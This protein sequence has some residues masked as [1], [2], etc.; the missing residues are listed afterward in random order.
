MNYLAHI[1]LCNSVHSRYLL[2]RLLSSLARIPNLPSLHRS[3]LRSAVP[4][5][6]VPVL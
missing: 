2:L 6:I 4:H 1:T 3:Y 5:L